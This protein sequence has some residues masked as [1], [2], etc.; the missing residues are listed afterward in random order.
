MS[1]LKKIIQERGIDSVQAE[2]DALREAPK[3]TPEQWFQEQLQQ[4]SIHQDPRYP[5]SL[6]FK[7]NGEVV[8]EQDSANDRLWVSKRQILNILE[9]KFSLSYE[10]AKE[11][12]QSMVQEHFKIE[13][14]RAKDA[15]GFCFW[16]V[17]V[18]K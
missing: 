5:N 14:G 12:V 7:I 4:M 8:L 13:V 15:N 3:Q 10:Q 18:S 1:Y 6:F 11:L 2:L 9:P 16:W 17:G